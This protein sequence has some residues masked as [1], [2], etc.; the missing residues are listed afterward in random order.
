MTADHPIGM[1][2]HIT[3]L[4]RSFYNTLLTCRRVDGRWEG[5][6]KYYKVE[7]AQE[8]VK[9]APPPTEMLLWR[10]CNLWQGIQYHTHAHPAKEDSISF[11]HKQPFLLA[12]VFLSNMSLYMFLY[13]ILMYL[14]GRHP[15]HPPNISF[16]PLRL[17]NVLHGEFVCF[18]ST[19]APASKC[20]LLSA[21]VVIKTYFKI[22]SNASLLRLGDNGFT[23]CFICHFA[24]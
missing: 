4:D 16:H 9:M 5:A 18:S 23:V 22:W 3:N 1:I 21:V 15:D 8:V 14:D 12:F 6:E 7:M 13:F 11:L 19:A 24:L 17:S 10:S 20:P 2:C